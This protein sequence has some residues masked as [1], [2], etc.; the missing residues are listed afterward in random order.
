MLQKFR[1]DCVVMRC[2]TP[3]RPTLCDFSAPW[4]ALGTIYVERR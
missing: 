2:A 1:Q 4:V 3:Q